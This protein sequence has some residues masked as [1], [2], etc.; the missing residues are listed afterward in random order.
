MTQQYLIS[1]PAEELKS[2]DLF[3]SVFSRTDQ[4]YPQPVRITE[5]YP[6]PPYITIYLE[7]GALVN[8]FRGMNILIAALA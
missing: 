7:D 8:V 1:K 5:I 4:H 6:D 3:V 2:G